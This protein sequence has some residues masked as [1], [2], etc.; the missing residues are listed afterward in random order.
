MT[1]RQL[2]RRRGVYRTVLPNFPR[3]AIVSAKM[4]GQRVFLVFSFFSFLSPFESFEPSVFRDDFRFTPVSS[5]DMD[6]E[7]ADDACD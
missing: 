7:G 5:V 1:G 2:P 3:H 4:W 6:L